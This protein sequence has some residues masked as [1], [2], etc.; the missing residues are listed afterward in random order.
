MQS[1]IS[2]IRFSPLSSTRATQ[3]S[4]PGVAV[5]K[6]SSQAL[7][8]REELIA[9]APEFARGPLQSL[10]AGTL[11][12]GLQASGLNA[13]E[14]QQAGR[15]DYAVRSIV[16][17][18]EAA[19]K[20]EALGEPGKVVVGALTCHFTTIG[21]DTYA[22]PYEAVVESPHQ[23][24]GLPG[25]LFAG[26]DSQGVGSLASTWGF[27]FVD[28]GASVEVHGR[29]LKQTSRGVWDGYIVSGLTPRS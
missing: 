20:D 15:F 7:D 11:P 2:P 10:L 16:A 25:A 5:E 26:S 14:I 27:S 9:Q 13:A 3:S 4:Q 29:Y 22:G 19:G 12:A 28:H 21:A 18:D 24:S 17:R 6:T 23:P 1:T 8:T